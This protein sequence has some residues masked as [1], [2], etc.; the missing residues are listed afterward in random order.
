MNTRAPELSSDASS[1]GTKVFLNSM[2]QLDD[3]GRPRLPL[4]PVCDLSQR[5]GGVHQRKHRPLKVL[6]AQRLLPPLGEPGRQAADVGQPFGQD[7]LAD[8]LQFLH[9]SQG[10]QLLVWDQQGVMLALDMKS[11]QEDLKQPM[12]KRR[13]GNS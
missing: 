13:S 9:A 11:S 5:L 3:S 2:E 7:V 4:L 6:P 1:R 10:G 12:T 8:D